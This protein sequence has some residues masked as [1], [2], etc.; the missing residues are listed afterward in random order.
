[1]PVN[2]AGVCIERIDHAALSS[3][4][5]ASANNGRLRVRTEFSRKSE[6]P[7]KFQA[8]NVA[9]PK[10][11]HS[12]VLVTR[13]RRVDAPAIPYGS[14]QGIGEIT[15]P[16][17]AHGLRRWSRAQSLSEFL[18]GYELC[19]IAPFYARAAAGHR[20]HRTALHRSQHS[21][22]RHTAKS[23]PVRGALES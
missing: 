6:G 12:I 11:R 21:L 17:A 22:R 18:V 15:R 19:D 5:N 4:E 10:S 14:R 16:R 3:N 2:A 1:V 9:G 20:N 23:I 7:L 8:R 13:V